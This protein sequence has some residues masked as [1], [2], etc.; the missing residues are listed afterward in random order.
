MTF[1]K[2][3]METTNLGPTGIQVSRL[4]IGCMQAWGWASSDDTRFVATVRHA[5]DMGLNFLDTAPAYGN[6]H[7]EELVARAIAGRRHQV[8]IAT[9]FNFDRIHPEDIRL[10]LEQSLRRLRTD[11]I[12]VFQQH[13]PSPDIPVADTVGE[14]E[15]LKEAGKIRAIGVSNW[16][17]PEWQ[18]LGNSSRVE[19][20]QPCH[21]L[22]WRSIEPYV[23][24]L[25][26][27]HNIAVIPYSPLCQGVLTGRFKRL[28]DLPTVQSDPRLQNCRL[29]PDIFPSV[30]EVVK[31]VGAVAAKYGKTPAQTALRWLLDQDGIT[32]TIVGA[33]SPE[34]VMENLA[35]LDWRLEPI[36]WQ[37][38]SDISW[39]LS[40]ELSPLDTLWGWHP[41][42]S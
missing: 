27:Q 23:L 35:A 14:L 30:L 13:W 40:A 17:E 31:A 2:G 4:C 11:Y 15:R 3:K 39:P 10:S 7:S 29:Q 25:C 37:W 41:K 32:A 20:L 34:Q 9:K 5:L 42:T 6:G 18:E 21:N 24:P 33:S 26:R 38:L 22:L 28:T 12:D 1:K 19:S 36:D 8:V 16:M